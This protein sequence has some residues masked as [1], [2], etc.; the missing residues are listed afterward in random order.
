MN[1]SPAGSTSLTV[2]P[3]TSRSEERRVGN[4]WGLLV[5]A[6]TEHTKSLLV[7]SRSVERVTV[8]VSVPVMLPGV[9]SVVPAGGVT[10]A[11]LVTLLLVNPAGTPKV[12]V[13]RA[14]RSLWFTAPV[15]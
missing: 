6:T 11:L 2:A 1:V 5:P 7:A 14:G 15:V 4:E 8:S 13:I 10:V 12:T 3:V 9:G